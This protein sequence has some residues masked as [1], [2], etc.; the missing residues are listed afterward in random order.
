MTRPQWPLFRGSQGTAKEFQ[1][2]VSYALKRAL[3]ETN[4]I[5]A[6]VVRETGK[7]PELSATHSCK[8]SMVT[9]G[10]DS[11]KPALDLAA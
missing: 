5:G 3:Q 6:G 7:A 2:S 1:G 4:G 9:V 11:T 10:S 8:E